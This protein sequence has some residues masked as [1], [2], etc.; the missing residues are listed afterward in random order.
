MSG[1]YI[2]SL[3]ATDVCSGWTVAVPLLVRKQSLVVQGIEAIAKQ[4]PVPIRGIDTDND[5]AFLNETLRNNCANRQIEFTRSR[6]YRK[7]DQTWIAQ[8]EHWLVPNLASRSL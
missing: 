7:N 3:V 2:H 1:A 4:L 8:H 5:S 6:P